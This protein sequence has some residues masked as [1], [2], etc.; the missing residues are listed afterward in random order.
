LILASASPRR[1]ELLTAAGLAFVIDPADVDERRFHDESPPALVERLA[2]LKAQT[3]L[4]RRPGATVLAA[5]T[6]VVLGD[7]VLGKPDDDEDARRM[8]QALSGRS[9]AVLT[10]IALVSGERAWS[11]VEST[12]VWFSALS[13][14]E[15]A[16]Y[17]ASGEPRDKAGAYGIQGLASRFIPRIEGSYSNVVGLPVAAVFEMMKE[18][19]AFAGRPVR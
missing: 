3:V 18:L 13:P 6:A 16:A 19:P 4:A 5:D 9:H 11:R 2:L 14:E 12:T 8:L 10:G 15:I 7:D 17:V 1:R